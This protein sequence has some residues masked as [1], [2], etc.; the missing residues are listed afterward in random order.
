[1]KKK[2]LDASVWKF[3]LVGVGN[4]LLCHG[5][6]VL[7]GG[8]GLLAVHRHRLRGR[9]GD[10]LFSQPLTSPSKAVRLSGRLC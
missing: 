6:H 2:L 1:M 5:A 10:E 8:A 3:L 4:T 7:A 9:G